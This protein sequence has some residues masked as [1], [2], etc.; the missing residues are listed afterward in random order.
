MLEPAYVAEKIASL[1]EQNSNNYKAGRANVK[2]EEVIQL[3][4]TQLQECIY[5]CG[6]YQTS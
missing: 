2:L 1:A 5:R 3:K 6:I 4:D